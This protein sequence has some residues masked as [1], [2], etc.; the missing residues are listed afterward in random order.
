MLIRNMKRIHHVSNGSKYHSLNVIIILL[1]IKQMVSVW[2]Y[3]QR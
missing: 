2:L 1:I 3:D